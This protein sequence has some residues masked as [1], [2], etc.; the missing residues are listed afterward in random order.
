MPARVM[1]IYCVHSAAASLWMAC[2]VGKWLVSAGSPT[3][4]AMP[5]TLSVFD[6]FVE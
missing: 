4:S 3:H 2:L 1:R 5:G 6:E